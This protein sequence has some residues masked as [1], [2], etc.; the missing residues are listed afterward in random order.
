MKLNRALGPLLLLALVAGVGVAL[1]FS[2]RSAG[3]ERAAR[4]VVTVK[5]VVGSEKLN[6]LRDPAVLAEL[7]KNGVDLQVETAGSREMALRPDLKTFDFAFPAGVPGAAK[8]AEVT[9]AHDRYDAF[10]TPMVVASWKPIASV[11]AANGIVRTS[12][13]TYEI[14]DMKRLLAAIEAGKRWNE[15]ANNKSYAIGKS[16][17]ISSTDVRKSNSAAMYLALASYVFNGNNIVDSQ[18]QAAKIV[19]QVAPLFTRQGYQESSSAGPFEDYTTMGMGKAPLVMSYEAQF[20]EYAIEHPSG[21]NSDMVLL[22]PQPTIFTK[23]ILIPFDDK[24]KKVG[25]L[26]ANDPVLQKL[27]IEHGFRNADTEDMRATW[28]RANLDLP[29]QLIDV[30]DPPSF[31][32]IEVMIKGIETRIASGG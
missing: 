14:I 12:G 31:D 30:V 8:I 7:R 10:Y 24:G 18:A 25:E 2:A 16:I 9:G 13:G 23:H 28:K 29:V 27:A 19:P 5:G 17:L 4:A 22:Y 20:I 6:L 15:L 32:V 21:R 26:F 11:L 3:L 1:Y